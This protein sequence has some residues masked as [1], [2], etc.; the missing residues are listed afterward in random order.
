[1]LPYVAKNYINEYGKEYV[2][3]KMSVNQIQINYF[4][5]R[6]NIVDFKMFEADERETFV[7]FDTLMVDINHAGADL[8]SVP[9]ISWIFNPIFIKQIQYYP[10]RLD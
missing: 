7:A 2:G 10:T 3:R 9:S 1:M 5:V 6:F 8:Q 4:S